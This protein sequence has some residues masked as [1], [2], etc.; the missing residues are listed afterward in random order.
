MSERVYEII[1]VADPNLAEP[2][3]ETLAAQV[4]GFVE[5]EGGAIQKRRDVGQEA[6]RL[7]RAAAT[8]RA[9]TR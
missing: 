7:H 6:P 9:T 2:E 5:K 8:A 1:F 4:Q 3:V